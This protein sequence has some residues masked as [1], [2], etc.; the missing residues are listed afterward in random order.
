MH[1]LVV[2][3]AD[4][5]QKRT[6]ATVAVFVTDSNDNTP[7]FLASVYEGEIGEGS[8]VGTAVLQVTAI[9]KDHGKN[10]QITYAIVSGW[11]I[12]TF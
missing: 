9:D 4:E 6:L 10:A 8:A 3:A 1:L 12:F 11:F 5:G 2:E 7:H